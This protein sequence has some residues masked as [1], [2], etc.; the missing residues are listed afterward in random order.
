[1]VLTE[2]YLNGIPSFY[3]TDV[4]FSIGIIPPRATIQFVINIDELFVELN[5]DGDLELFNFLD[6][7]GKGEI[8]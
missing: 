8:K 3:L 6:L 1:M 5:Y 7:Y 4:D 2:L